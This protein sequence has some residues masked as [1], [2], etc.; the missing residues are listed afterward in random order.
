MVETQNACWTPAMLV[1]YDNGAVAPLTIYSHQTPSLFGDL[2]GLALNWPII[3]SIATAD[4]DGY[5]LVAGDGGV[6]AFGGAHFWG[7]MGAT[8][9]NEPVVGMATDPDGA[10][11]WMVAADGG[12]FA[13][14]APFRGSV[15][16]VLAPGQVVNRPIVGMIPYGNGY[17]MFAADGGVF[18]FSNREFAGSLGDNP[19]IAPIV[20]AVA[21]PSR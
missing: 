17:L 4:H 13:F 3:D 18:N 14:E 15:P 5:W 16:A 10:G 6:F 19:P 9:L 1:V 2:S 20:G 7:S 21:I 12:L 8:P 11:Y